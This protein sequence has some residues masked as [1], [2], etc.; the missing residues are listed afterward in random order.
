MSYKKLIY[1]DDMM[2][3][4]ADENNIKYHEVEIESQIDGELKSI[5]IDKNT[6]KITIR[7]EE[8]VRKEKSF[9]EYGDY[10]KPKDKDKNFAINIIEE[11][12]V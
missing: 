2:L 3:I 12:E 6:G 5:V 11:S 10:I 8:D 7:F 4:K 1:R 9:D